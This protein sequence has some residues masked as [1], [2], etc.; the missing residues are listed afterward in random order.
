MQLLA[1]NI[2]FAIKHQYQSSGYLLKRSNLVPG[3]ITFSAKHIFY[4]NSEAS[5]DCSKGRNMIAGHVV[6]T[7]IVEL[8]QSLELGDS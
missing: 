6:V 7:I 3:E 1:N 4:Q 8:S 2:V 5:V